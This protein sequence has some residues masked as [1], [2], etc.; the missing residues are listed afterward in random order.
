MTPTLLEPL[1]TADR[2]TADRFFADAPAEALVAAVTASD[3]DLLLELIGREEV[4][5]AA[6]P[7]ILR[8]L[9]EYADADR[10]AGV[11]GTVRFD[12]RR[13]SRLLESHAIRL[14]RG[15]VDLVADRDAAEAADVVLTTSLLRFVRLVS[16]ERN[17]GLE[18]LGGGLDVEGDALLALAVGGIFRV[19]GHAEAAVDPTAL[20]PDEVARAVGEASTDHLRRVM[21]GGFRPVVL[22]EVFRR[23]PSF[24][25]ERRAANLDLVV[26]F[27]LGGGPGEPDRYVVTLRDGAA[28]VTDEDEGRRD[29][30]IVCDAH[31]FLRLATGHLGAVAGVMRGRLGVKG[32]K[33]KALQFAS[34]IRFPTG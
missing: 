22:E 18:Y 5:A 34:V 27:R 28:A 2:A 19:P 1:R 29:A 25:D 4:R 10:L 32:D 11:S 3:D 8:R 15:A 7:G 30:T 24:V 31:D 9:E 26:G 6:V 20:D 12:L 21:A 33:A 13:G 17:A 16:G 23:L 14:D